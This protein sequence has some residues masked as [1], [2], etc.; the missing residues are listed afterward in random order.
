MDLKKALIRLIEPA[1]P[2]GS[3][4]ENGKLIREAFLNYC[5]DVK[6]DNLGNIIGFK[7]GLSSDYKLMLAA[8]MDEIG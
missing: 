6:C 4:I 8:H 2:S 5:D 1:I 3:E 7:R